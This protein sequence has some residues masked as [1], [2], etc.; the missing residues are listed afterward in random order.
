MEGRPTRVID[1]AILDVFMV[2]TRSLLN[3]AP[4]PTNALWPRDVAERSPYRVGIGSAEVEFRGRAVG[5]ADGFG[6]SGDWPD[7]P[8]LTRGTENVDVRNLGVRLLETAFSSSSICEWCLAF[9]L[10]LLKIFI[11]LCVSPSLGR[12][13]SFFLVLRSDT[14]V[15]LYWCIG[16]TSYQ[17]VCKKIEDEWTTSFFQLELNGGRWE[18]MRK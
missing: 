11:L 8:A 14:I 17:N 3:G 4:W 18:E 1:D 7:I 13:E 5:M 2:A 15:K 9:S 12:S 6:V 10:S 16:W